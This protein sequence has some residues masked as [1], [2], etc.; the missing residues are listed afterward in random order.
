[1]TQKRTGNICTQTG[2][3]GLTNC[4]GKLRDTILDWEDKLP[5]QD[6]NDG[7][8]EARKADLSLCLGT[9]LQ[10][11]PSGKIPLLTLKNKGEMV[12][13][14]LQRTKYD[15]KAGLV[16]HSYVDDVMEGVMKELGM[17][18]PE[19]CRDFY[20]AITSELIQEPV[21]KRKHESSDDED[22]RKPN[23][24]NV[25]LLKSE[26]NCLKKEDDE[27][28]SDLDDVKSKSDGE[29]CPKSTFLNLDS[30]EKI[31]NES[32]KTEN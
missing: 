19:F 15:K 6:L 4:R 22:E 2:K 9:T 11:V 10:I 25:R 26:N 13:V 24:R 1:M 28:V 23:N 32:I 17:P 21:K 3:R 5:V 29:I 8:A 18:I 30:D 14:N 31:K 16:I 12:I 20:D 27:S 7:E